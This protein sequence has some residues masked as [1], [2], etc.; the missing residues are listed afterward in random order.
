MGSMKVRRR[1]GDLVY[2][3]LFVAPD[4]LLAGLSAAEPDECCETASDAEAKAENN[5]R[6]HPFSPRLLVVTHI[7]FRR[8]ARGHGEYSCGFESD[9]SG[10]HNQCTFVIVGQF[11]PSSEPT[12]ASPHPTHAS[13]ILTPSV[14]LFR[15]QR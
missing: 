12:S 15:I 13:H 5:K 6:F 9:L 2:A 14:V 4:P 10:I 8:V 7:I 1:G 3:G 11:D